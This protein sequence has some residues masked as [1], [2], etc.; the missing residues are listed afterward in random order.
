MNPTAA[1]SDIPQ[2]K[3]TGCR[4]WTPAPVKHT[5]SALSHTFS[6]G[7][8]SDFYCKSATLLW[9]HEHKP[10]SHQPQKPIS[11]SFCLLQL[12]GRGQLVVLFLLNHEKSWTEICG[13]HATCQN[14]IKTVQY[15]PMDIPTSSP[16]SQAVNHHS[17]CTMTQLCQFFHQLTKWKHNGHNSSFHDSQ[18][19]FRY[20]HH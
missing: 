5:Q 17:A 6:L 9:H 2:Q 19:L 1:V 14:S 12:F 10:M 18:P 4:C 7:D 3:W 13:W 8:E 16:I 20:W 15:K 11:W